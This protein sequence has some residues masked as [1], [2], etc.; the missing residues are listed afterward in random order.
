M[1]LPH[2]L[3]ATAWENGFVPETHGLPSGELEPRMLPLLPQLSHM[4]SAPRQ[5]TT[6]GNALLTRFDA[7]V[8]PYWLRD[9]QT[10]FGGFT[11]VYEYQWE[12]ETRRMYSVAHV[13]RP[14]TPT[15]EACLCFSLL[16]TLPTSKPWERP[17]GQKDPSRSI[18]LDL[19]SSLNWQLPATVLGLGRDIARNLTDDQQVQCLPVARSSIPKWTY[20]ALPKVKDFRTFGRIPA[21]GMKPQKMTYHVCA[22]NITKHF[23]VPNLPDDEKE[24]LLTVGALPASSSARDRHCVMCPV[25]RG[26][27][28]LLP[29][30][31]CYNWVHPGCSYQTHLGRVCPCHVQILDPKRKIMV[32]KYPYHEDLVVLPTR[33]NLRID[34]KSI[35]RDAKMSFGPQP[36]ET[37]CEMGSIIV[38]KH[39][40]REA[41]MALCRTCVDARRVTIS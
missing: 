29:C 4:V 37:A 11:K 25:R 26:S 28:R 12:D 21:C 8:R 14:R 27:P 18:L 20:R 19:K 30:A 36:G 15:T 39:I 6:A 32:L 31:L 5:P 17:T 7:N 3:E 23:I 2:P 35:S 41:C 13:I 9:W 38:D 16:R 33:P 34:T 1:A 24:A 40:V 22:E 10:G